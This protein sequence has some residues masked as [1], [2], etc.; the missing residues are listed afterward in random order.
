[1]HSVDWITPHPHGIHIRPADMWVDVSTAQAHVI[2]THGHADHA[3]GGHGCTYATPATLDIMKLRYGTVDGVGLAYGEP[4]LRNGV[5][6][7]LHPAGH[8][9]GSAQVL[10]TYRGERVIITGDYKRREDPTCAPFELIPCDVLVTEATFALPVFEHPPIR[11]EIDKLLAIKAE[12]PARAI[13]VGAYALGK[14]Q[15]VIVSLREAGYDEPIYLHG[16]MEKMCALYEA[17]GIALGDL[18]PATASASASLPGQIVICPPSALHDRWSR[19]FADP[20]LA[21]A[22]GWMQIRQRA[23]QKNIDLPLIISDHAD[24]REL[25]DTISALRPSETWVTHGRAE[26]LIRW[27]ELNQLKARALHLVGREDEDE[28]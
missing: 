25:T 12:T 19:R 14:A 8:I 11:D 1:M 16:A 7:S 15:R 17:H 26:A 18:R 20:V 5:E 13:I 4:L 24:W 9:L 10:V 28:G 2:V 22:S 21:V 6:I 27:C 3:R 23:R